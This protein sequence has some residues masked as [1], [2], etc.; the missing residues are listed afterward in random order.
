[1]LEELNL[2]LIGGGLLLGLLFGVVAQRSRFCLVAAVSNLALM[3]DYRQVHA[4]LAALGVA[5]LGTGLLEALQWVD[6]GAT[7]YRNLVFNWLGALGGGLLFGMGA[8][9]AGGC[10]S[11][12]LVRSAEGNLGALA[13]LLSFALVGMM[14]LF[15]VL[16]PVRVWLVQATARPALPE[17]TSLSGLLG[18]PGIVLPVVLSLACFMVI[19]RFGN[20]RANIRFILAGIAIGL[21]LTAGWWVTGVLGQDEFDP[22]TPSSL[23]V[24]GPLSRGVVYLTTA[25]FSGSG[26]ALFL[27]LGLMLG[28][29]ASAL[30]GRD[31]R[32]VA[33]AGDRVGS[34]FSGGALMGIGAMLAG[35]CNIG[36]GLTGVS[37][38][39]IQSFIALSG[40]LCGMWLVLWRMQR[41]TQ[42]AIAHSS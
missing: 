16:E 36:Q 30:V 26:F 29:F 7:S 23:A 35:G 10:A 3:R 25:Q 37:T 33:P 17:Q 13:T 21:I 22:L 2:W 9:L 4:Y 14:T 34:Y 31:F 1:M 8:M 24:A 41:T 12:T 28:A 20:W 19:Y 18:L 15:G 40:M 38:L 5:T 27:V 42:S 39:S 11:R 32:W 6:I